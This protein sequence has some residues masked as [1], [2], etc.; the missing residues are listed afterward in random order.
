[1]DENL[2]IIVKIQDDDALKRLQKNLGYKITP[3]TKEFN[4]NTR[5]E[6]RYK[7]AKIFINK[8]NYFS[9]KA[10]DE[11]KCNQHTFKYF[12]Y[13]DYKYKIILIG[14]KED[15][16]RVLE[17]KLT[18]FSFCYFPFKEF[19]K[20]NN[21]IYNPN[22]K[23]KYPIFIV[24]KGR[25]DISLTALNFLKR[26]IT[27]FR[28][29]VEPQ[30]YD[31]YSKFFEEENLLILDMKYKEDYETLDEYGTS[32]GVGPGAARNF[33]WDVA[34][35]EGHKFHWVFD[36]N[37]RSFYGLY[38]FNEMRVID[39]SLLYYTER[40]SESFDNIY[41]A[42]LSYFSFLVKKGANKPYILNSRIYSMIL[43]R[44]DTPY[45]W[46]GRYNED[47]ILSLDI[48]KDGHATLQCNIFNG[49][50]E[51]TQKIVGG[52]TDEFYKNEGTLP[53]SM[54]LYKTYP[55]YSKLK[56]KIKRWHHFVN[57]NPFKNNPVGNFV[58]KPFD[59]EEIYK[60][61][62]LKDDELQ[63]RNDI[64]G[65]YENVLGIEVKNKEDIL[66]KLEKYE[67]ALQ[68]YK[69]E[70]TLKKSKKDKYTS[71]YIIKE[72]TKYGLVIN[73]TR[74]FDEKE[75]NK[76]KDKLDEKLKEKGVNTLYNIIGSF[77]W[78]DIA[79][80]CF[81]YGYNMIDI[82]NVKE[83]ENEKID[84]TFIIKNNIIPESISKK[85]IPSVKVELKSL[86]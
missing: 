21:I 1:M 25:W 28:I 49:H 72:P 2:K 70:R 18:K 48:L 55:K 78:E 15:L 69:R 26:G 67:N 77:A 73:E 32:K 46:R 33:A 5:L 30:E 43:L 47:T 63:Y 24:S 76:Y 9:D 53:K 61:H 40:V 13:Y 51:D 27:D 71:E 75:F 68:T 3:R 4:L 44:T 8:E 50:K 17:Q 31:M 16:E 56:Y 6:T 34:R 42:G 82:L 12:N 85:N 23:H 39:Q 60:F 65:F 37:I 62:T 14:K 79:H 52:N 84:F 54:M 66:R 57:Y 58:G 20:N 83:L 7:D 38:N 59:E 86:W 11:M 22:V 81:D 74:E 45:K 10:F 29:I 41:Q 80:F 36:D 35:K 64:I 19:D